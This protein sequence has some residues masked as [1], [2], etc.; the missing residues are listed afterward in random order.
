[1]SLIMV[2]GMGVDYGI[3]LVDSADDREMPSAQRC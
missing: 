3:F 2:M 1:M